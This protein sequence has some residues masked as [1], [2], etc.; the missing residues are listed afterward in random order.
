MLRRMMM[1]ANSGGGAFWAVPTYSTADGATVAGLA[2]RV[3]WT[4]TVSGGSL[5]CNRLRVV[6]V[7]AWSA[8][9]YVIIHRNSDNVVMASATIPLVS[10]NTW[11]D[12]AVTPFTLANG[13]AYTISTRA[14][15]ASRTARRNNTRTIMSGLSSVSNVS[16]IDDSRPTTA[17]GNTYQLCDFGYA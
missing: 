15:G 16:G 10:A 14:G 1:A 2:A 12:A 9:E 8:S 17:T 6:M 5:L 13:V 3:G 7:G 11:A 4:F